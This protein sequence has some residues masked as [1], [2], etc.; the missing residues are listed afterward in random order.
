MIYV[1]PAVEFLD[2]PN[3]FYPGELRLVT[4][5]KAAEYEALGYLNKPDAAEQ[6]ATLDIQNSTI[7][8]RSTQ[9]G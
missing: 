9:H 1:K 7:G 3:R 4:E 8:H 5:A 2:G 6:E